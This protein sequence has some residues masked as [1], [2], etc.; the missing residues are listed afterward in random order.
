M[1]IE[2][3]ALR[4]NRTLGVWEG[5][6]VLAGRRK[7][8]VAAYGTEP[9][10]GERTP[11]PAQFAPIKATVVSA[12]EKLDDHVAEAAPAFAEAYETHWRGASRRRCAAS[13]IAASFVLAQ[14][15]IVDPANCSLK[16]RASR[17]FA[18]YRPEISLEDGAVVGARLE[19][20]I[21]ENGQLVGSFAMHHILEVGTSSRE[22]PPPSRKRVA[23]K[24]VAPTWVA[25]MAKTKKDWRG[26]IRIARRPVE[27]VS[28]SAAR[29]DELLG[30]LLGSMRDVM[31]RA[32][33][34]LAAL[35]NASWREGAKLTASKLAARIRLQR[36]EFSGD[37]W[38]LLLADDDLFGGHTI[39]VFAGD[40][41]V[42]T[43]L[44]G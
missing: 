34:E 44:L 20:P 22:Q 7:V 35:Y 24:R 16:F 19:R 26:T 37:A 33:K 10:R 2:P 14:I 27:V 28:D 3:A 40:D 18:N 15:F 4:Y 11:S 39:E 13:D 43:N 8:A 5:S 42:Q 6:I 17:W 29:I 36:I 23:R 1:I 12:L 31:A 9:D 32:T 38:T 41:E 21:G 25:A 30:L